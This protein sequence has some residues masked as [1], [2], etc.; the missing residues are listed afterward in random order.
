MNTAPQSEAGGGD[1]AGFPFRPEMVALIV[2]VAK[3]GRAPGRAALI[4][5]AHMLNLA[6]GDVLQLAEWREREAA[7]AV[8]V[9]AARD[10]VR[11]ARTPRRADA[12][13]IG[14]HDWHRD[15]R[16]LPN[17]GRPRKEGTETFLRTC[18]DAWRL[19]TGDEPSPGRN[20]ARFPSPSMRFI[21]GCAE[22]AALA[23]TIEPRDPRVRQEAA[24]Q[25]HPLKLS[26]SAHGG[27]SRHATLRTQLARLNRSRILRDMRR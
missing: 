26:E 6:Y 3:P 14:A 5:A 21:A 2:L 7:R 8:A 12:A 15:L 25:F 19:L 1:P 4:D 23:L 27:N 11:A 17:G 10:R 22:V 16:Q 18:C 13:L 24:A 20:A 9:K